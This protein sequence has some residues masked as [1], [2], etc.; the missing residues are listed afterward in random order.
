ML[1][2]TAFGPRYS[3]ELLGMA[4]ID[5][6]NEGTPFPLPTWVALTTP[7]L[8]LLSTVTMILVGLAWL[9]PVAA[10]PLSRSARVAIALPGLSVLGV[11]LLGVGTAY[12]PEATEAL[13]YF[14]D[15]LLNL[16]AMV[17]LG[18]LIAARVPGLARFVVLTLCVSAFGFFGMVGDYLIMVHWSDANWDSPPGSG[19]L[20][21]ALLLVSGCAVL[22]MTAL[23]RQ[24]AQPV[25]DVEL[26]EVPA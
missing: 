9:V 18:L 3:D 26:D 7:G 24:P 5:R 14:L 25:P 6:M 15:F 17:G 22:I 1:V 13:G 2:G 11:A 19:Y 8:L 23:S 20:T 4:C 10:L 16:F 12:L 21:A